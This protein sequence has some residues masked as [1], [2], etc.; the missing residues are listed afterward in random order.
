LT[1]KTSGTLAVTFCE[2]P[3]EKVDICETQHLRNFRL[4]EIG[5]EEQSLGPVHSKIDH[6]LSGALM[7]VLPEEGGETAG[8][9]SG[10]AGHL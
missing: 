8:G 4:G 10:Q 3:I 5:F 2:L 9:Q 6:K 1:A 7:K